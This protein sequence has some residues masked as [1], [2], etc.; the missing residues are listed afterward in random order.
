MSDREPPPEPVVT[1]F[2]PTARLT[3]AVTTRGEIRFELLVPE[4]VSA[5]DLA[6]ELRLG[7]YG[8]LPPVPGER[9]GPI[10]VNEDERDTSRITVLYKPDRPRKPSQDMPCIVSIFEETDIPITKSVKQGM[11]HAFDTLKALN[12][13]GHAAAEVARRGAKKGPPGRGSR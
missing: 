9:V 5:P 7:F 2:H 6:E 4:N 13:Q 8:G 12:A 1:E 11:Q 10:S 3:R